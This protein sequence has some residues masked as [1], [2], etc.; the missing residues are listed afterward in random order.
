LGL[1]PS[2][3]TVEA[4]DEEVDDSRTVDRAWGLRV[5]T[6]SG[7]LWRVTGGLLCSGLAC[8]VRCEFLDMVLPGEYEEIDVGV[9]ETLKGLGDPEYRVDGVAESAY[10]GVGSGRISVGPIS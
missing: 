4:E 3:T 8:L 9:E 7:V 10:C 5:V 1:L 6:S 2:A